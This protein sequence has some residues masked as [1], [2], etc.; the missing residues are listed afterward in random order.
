MMILIITREVKTFMPNRDAT[1]PNQPILELVDITKRYPIKVKGKKTVLNALDRVSLTVRQGETI[2][3]VGESG[4]GK[5][6]TAKIMLN[7]TRPTSGDVFLEGDSLFN[8]NKNT[9]KQKSKIQ[10]V[11][12]DPYSSLDPRMTIYE[13]IEEPL[14][15][16][17]KDD[18]SYRERKIKKLMDQVQLPYAFK[19]RHPHQFSG[20]QRQRIGI[21]RALALD[22]KIVVCD[23]P[24]SALDVSVRSEILN[25]LV[26]L[27]KDI[28]MSYVFISHDL[29][30]VRQVSD[31]VAVM[32]LGKIVEEAPNLEI[33][34]SPLHPYTEALM[35]SIPYPN[36]KEQ[37]NR[38]RIILQGDVPSPVNPP[39]GCKF[40]T[41]CWIAKSICKTE[42][43][44]LREIQPNHWAACHFAEERLKG[45]Q[46]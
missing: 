19:D 34:N 3:L 28:H 46:V 27:Q 13:I 32:Y 23:E 8:S 18:A 43:P 42:E 17:Y 24:V 33:F 20:G 4:C 15:V 2:G 41:R 36:P 16:F 31:R 11:F 39:T 22:P 14:Q 1:G 5:S 25:L 29:S 35:S 38:E 26:Q 12:Q 7:L 37:R 21:A 30:V 10:M 9:Y 44:P 40:H 6:T 45:C